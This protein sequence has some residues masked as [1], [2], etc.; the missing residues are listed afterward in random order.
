MICAKLENLYHE[1]KVSNSM[2]FI[3]RNANCNGDFV[4][5]KSLIN[6]YWRQETADIN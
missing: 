2:L 5:T 3:C 1:D 4:K 6:T